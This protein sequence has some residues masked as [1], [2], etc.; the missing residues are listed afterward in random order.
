[1]AVLERTLMGPGPSNPYPEATAALSASML[2]H[3]DPAFLAI[4]DETCDRLGRC[5]RPVVRAEAPWGRPLDP[6]GVL[7]ARAEVLER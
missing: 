1:M 7:A 6:A 4:L 3:L 2:G 5:G